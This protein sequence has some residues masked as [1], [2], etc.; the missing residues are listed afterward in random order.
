VKLPSFSAPQVSLLALILLSPRDTQTPFGSNEGGGKLD[1]KG[2][3]SR[4]RLQIQQ[5]KQI[6]Y[7][8]TVLCQEENQTPER[9]GGFAAGIWFA[10]G[11]IAPK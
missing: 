6:V 11:S 3:L 2:N 9:I 7:R 5:S 4:S 10:E 8:F 1:V